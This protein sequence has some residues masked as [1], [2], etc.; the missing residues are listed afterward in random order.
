[1][2]EPQT[3]RPA[4]L[5]RISQEPLPSVQPSGGGSGPCGRFRSHHRKSH[6]T[7]A[8]PPFRCA[9]RPLHAPAGHINCPRQIAGARRCW[10]CGERRQALG[11]ATVGASMRA[12]HHAWACAARSVHVPGTPPC[13]PKYDQPNTPAPI[14]E[15]GKHLLQL[16]AAR[17]QPHSID[18]LPS[19]RHGF[20]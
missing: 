14:L 16:P 8:Y 13:G 15:V 9:G 6:G 5:S 18:S 12:K 2:H 7:T 1:M 4:S 3:A 11:S 20:K 19:G 10:R 17:C